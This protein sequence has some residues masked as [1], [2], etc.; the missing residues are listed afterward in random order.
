MQAWKTKY[1]TVMLQHF[2]TDLHTLVFTVE[3]HTLSHTRYGTVGYNLMFRNIKVK[4]S[5]CYLTV[6]VDHSC[7]EI[8]IVKCWGCFC[9]LF[10][11]LS[12]LIVKHIV[13]HLAVWSALIFVDVV[14]FY[15]L[16]KMLLER[17]WIN[18]SIIHY[19]SQIPRFH[20][21]EPMSEKSKASLSLSSVFQ[22]HTL[23]FSSFGLSLHSAVMGLLNL[24]HQYFICEWGFGPACYLSHLFL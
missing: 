23:F 2:Q 5:M 4:T 6:Q 17:M 24:H 14:V 3:T 11:F 13:L 1:D 7:A 10:Y 20:S 18:K 22:T 9:V 12:L 8:S 21:A 15:M 16:W 19:K